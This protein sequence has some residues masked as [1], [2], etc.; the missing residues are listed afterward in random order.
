MPT[1]H[2]LTQTA[3]L[4]SADETLLA[5]AIRAGTAE[6]GGYLAP[7][8]NAPSNNAQA[9]A[10]TLPLM[11][12][13]ASG[14]LRRLL[15]GEF[16]PILPEFLALAAAKKVIA[17]PELV[18]ALL[19]IGKKELREPVLALVGERGRWLAGYN[20]VWAYALAPVDESAWE[21]GTTEERT[22]L[23]E[24]LRTSN[25]ARAR[26]LVQDTWKQDSPET[27]AVF[28][29]TFLAGLSMEDEPF[30]ETC[31]DDKRKEVREAA[32]YLLINLPQSRLVARM[33]ARLEPLV[34][35]KSKFLGGDTLT[36]TL[37]E[38]LDPAMKRDG[39]TGHSWRTGMGPKSTLLAEL[40]SFVPTELWSQKWNR[41]PEKLLQAALASEEKQ[42]LLLGWQVAIGR[43]GDSAWVAALAEIAVKHPEGRKI[44]SE[45]GWGGVSRHLPMEKLEGLAQSSISPLINEINDKHPLFDLLESY[46]HPWSEKLTRLVLGSVR[47]QAGSYHWR[48]MR[49]LPTFALRMPVSLADE[50]STGWPEKLA[51][52][53]TWVDQLIGILRFRKEMMEA[54]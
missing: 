52:W 50:F 38:G 11:S 54:L 14:L 35:I 4:G 6:L 46:P 53:D 30:I 42:A 41:T 51:G 20:P 34:Q 28:L 17:P 43:C 15:Q 8:L 37:P 3:M 33:L 2:A 1:F 27:R 32:Q 9:S 44:I 39:I 26:A 19:G 10:E 48:L 7:D 5:A 29:S 40:I 13:K 45:G 22:R 12:E 23:L 24:R 16:E 36:V 21:T 31:L 49:S 47:R 25:P 18:P